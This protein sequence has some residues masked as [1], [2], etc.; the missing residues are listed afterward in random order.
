MNL[1]IIEGRKLKRSKLLWILIAAILIMWIP[2]VLNAD[3]NFDM[4]AEGIS[5][6]NNF[7]I[8]GF[9]GFAWFLFPASIV[10]ITVLIAQT[11]RK[12]RG[13]FKMLSFPVHP[14]RLCLSKFVILLFL[15]AV[16]MLFM[17]LGYFLS[18]EAASGL[19]NYDF[20]VDVSMVLRT[21]GL[22]YLA[23]VPMAA[24]YYMLSVLI[25]SSVF[26]VGI[27]LALIVP[28]VLVMNTKAWFVYP[29]CYPF[30]IVT[31]Q[32]HDLATK[33]GSFDYE[34]VPWIPAAAVITVL[35]IVISC[36]FFGRGEV[37]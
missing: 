28:S 32:M 18:A 27:G 24:L 37:R 2:C 9:M 10:V 5:P 11:E 7:F 14:G 13:L 15:L 26:S 17:V 19:E 3:V 1:L 16:E 31:A 4:E 29:P 22:V 35:C 8:Q 34:L 36:I 30:R 21:A 20:S 33:M 23:S 25:T 6:E 12:N